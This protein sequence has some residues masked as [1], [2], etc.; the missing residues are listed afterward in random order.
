MF[1]WLFGRKAKKP[2]WT[3]NLHGSLQRSA[4]LAA[5]WTVYAGV[6]SM[7]RDGSYA[8]DNPEARGK[9]SPFDEE[10]FARGALAEFWA[11]QPAEVQATDPYLS[12]LARVRT[13]GLI[14][15][16]VW[17]YVREPGWRQPPGLDLGKLDTWMATEGAVAH[18]PLTLAF[19]VPG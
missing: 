5:A 6:K 19:V 2:K 14:R 16:Y 4:K 15:E 11:V 10:C 17:R 8:D 18:E 9:D 13:A 1:E 12:L 7:V 3:I